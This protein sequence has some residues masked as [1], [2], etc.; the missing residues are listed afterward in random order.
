MAKSVL[1]NAQTFRF[2]DIE[3]HESAEGWE[4]DLP[5]RLASYEYLKRDGGEQEPMGAGLKTFTFRCCFLGP[6]C[7]S[8]YQA[9]A[10]SVQQEPRGKL[11]HPRLGTFDV[12]C[13]GIKGRED[14]SREI[15]SINFTIE[16]IENQVDQSI[17]LD[18]QFGTQKRAADVTDSLSDAATAVSNILS[19]H[20]ANTV[21][22]AVTAARVA[23]T[24]AMERFRDLAVESSQIEAPDP[25]LDKMLEVTKQR[26][27]EA[28]DAL[29]KVLTYTLESDVSLTDARTAI[30]LSY[31]AC[32]QLY[33]A[34]LASKPPIIEHTVTTA[35]PLTS[36]ALNLYGSEARSKME[37]IYLLNPNLRMPHWVAAG[38]MLRV[39]APQVKL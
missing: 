5:I 22:A 7:G 27:D 8:R 30:Y 38:T 29:A 19:N 1:S 24:K 18:S 32:I 33:S 4:D 9:L 34:V 37:E 11:V 3:L 2:K 10:R 15:D 39:V 25:T 23:M 14:P 20:I 12:A 16:F 35:M 28:L 31:A 6:D 36:I 13:R 26:R 21:Y 17:Q